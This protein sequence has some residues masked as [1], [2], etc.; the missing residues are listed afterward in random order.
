MGLVN[1]NRAFYEYKIWEDRGTVVVAEK[2]A[3]QFKDVA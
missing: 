1:S 2:E 3:L